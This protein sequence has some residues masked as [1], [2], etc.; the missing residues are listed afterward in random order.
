MTVDPP[1]W[2]GRTVVCIA[3][4]PS[5]TPDDVE[6]VRRAGVPT[7][8]TNT[9]FRAAPWADVLFAFDARWWLFKDPSTGETYATETARVFAGRRLCKT[10]LGPNFGVETVANAP[11]FAGFGNSGVSA[12][13]VAMAA[14]ASKVVLL[15]FDCSFAPDGRKHWHGDHPRGLSNGVS[16]SKWPYQFKTI[17][18]AASRQGVRVINASRRTA[19]DCFERMDLEDALR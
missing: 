8:V 14:R 2:K 18:K 10:P 19:L 12:I 9:T 5:L 7:I 6:I 11:W 15:G 16:I 4:G 17:A 3:S 13:A 1:D